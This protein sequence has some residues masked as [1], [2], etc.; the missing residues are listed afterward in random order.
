MGKNKTLLKK[1]EEN[2]RGEAYAHDLA[3]G[4]SFLVCTDVKA[5]QIVHL[6]NVWFVA[7]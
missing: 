6:K 1:K 4:G 7:C 2:L 3:Y 5:H